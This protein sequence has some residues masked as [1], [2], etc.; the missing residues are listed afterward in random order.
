MF[1][2]KKTA[3]LK[4]IAYVSVPGVQFRRKL[5]ELDSSS[6]TAV[7]VVFLIIG[8]AGLGISFTNPVLTLVCIPFVALIGFASMMCVACDMISIGE[9]GA[10]F[11][12]SSCL[13]LRGRTIRLW[14]DVESIEIRSGLG[15]LDQP[16]RKGGSALK[17]GFRSGGQVTLPIHNF[18]KES[19]SAFVAA[20]QEWGKEGNVDR[21]LEYLPRLWD[22]E[23]GD[24]SGAKELSYTKFWEEELANNYS[25]TAFVPLQV[26]HKL[27]SESLT[28]LKQIA[29]GG[30]SAIYAVKD[31]QG[32]QHVLKESVIPST[33][34]DKTKEKVK[35]HFKRESEILI[36]LNHPNIAK[37]YDHFVDNSRDYLLLEYISGPD[38]RELVRQNGKQSVENV[39]KW[40][41]QMADVLLYLHTQSPPVVHRDISPDN[42]V[43]NQ[44]GDAVLIDFGAANEFVGEATGTLVG[45]QAYM[46][47][48]QI[49]G[50]VTPQSDIYSLGA[51]MHFLLTGKDPEPLSSSHPKSIEPSVPPALDELVNACTK[52]DLPDRVK[53]AQDLLE[54]LSQNCK[55]LATIGFDKGRENG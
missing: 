10:V 18:T 2:L 40:T 51:C 50:K 29:A 38:A 31:S 42:V 30:F 3:R 28:V 53:S 54:R 36:K 52:L 33:T 26:G 46:A 32:V 14:S 24:L 17:I 27:C 4:S 8:M 55:P 49:R 19:L 12:I 39:L 11:P 1:K 21:Q 5:R 34:D 48:E 22:Y 20:L 45:K 25:F 6:Q 37:V 15:S 35:E 41:A 16:I 43:I 44:S 7:F 13:P 9:K 47:P 23:N